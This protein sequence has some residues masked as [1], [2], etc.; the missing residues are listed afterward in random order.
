MAHPLV[1]FT[2]AGSLRSRT[3]LGYP[4]QPRS[5]SEPNPWQL[6]WQR[7]EAVPA[8]CLLPFCALEPHGSAGCLPMTARQVHESPPAPD[9]LD[10]VSGS[11]AAPRGQS[12]SRPRP[13]APFWSQ[14]Q[15]HN[16][17][18]P[19]CRAV[20]PTPKGPRG[21]K[22]CGKKP[23]TDKQWPVPLAYVPSDQVLRP[24]TADSHHERGSPYSHGHWPS[25]F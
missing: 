1:L 2:T 10:V 17:S 16:P 22:R 5:C 21:R 24:R 6:C 8:L 3:V 15:K 4:S 12:L 9:S 11:F 7:C 13:F 25:T 18:C 19:V 23:R 20:R 14:A